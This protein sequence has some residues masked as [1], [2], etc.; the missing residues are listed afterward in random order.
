MCGDGSVPD[1]VRPSTSTPP[2]RM[3][4][5]YA[6]QSLAALVVKSWYTAT[7]ALA[8]TPVGRRHGACR[9]GS[10]EARRGSA[11]RRCGR[12]ARRGHRPGQSAY[13]A[14]Q[15]AA[16]RSELHDRPARTG[17]VAGSLSGRGYPGAPRS[18]GGV[19]AGAGGS[20]LRTVGA[21]SR[22]GRGGAA[23]GGGLQSRR[24]GEGG[25]SAEHQPDRQRELGLQRSDAAARTATTPKAVSASVCSRRCSAAANLQAQVEIRTAEQ[26]QAVAEYGGVAL[27]AFGDVENA[28]TGEFI[29]A[30]REPLLAAV[31]RTTS[32]P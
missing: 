6:R 7:E 19:A 28:L 15:R 27:T 2:P 21:A 29:L 10:G 9:A 3:I 11:T 18:A 26:K 4:T 25:A 14:G 5:P 23:C 31:V 20:A 16:I 13:R 24:G 1:A 32:A 8:A 17:T 30:Q 22:C 12:C